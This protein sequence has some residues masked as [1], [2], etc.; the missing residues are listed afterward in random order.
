MK[1]LGFPAFGM[2]SFGGVGSG[3]FEVYLTYDKAVSDFI[4][5]NTGDLAY[6]CSSVIKHALLERFK[7]ARQLL[8]DKCGNGQE[9]MFALQPTIDNIK[10][11]TLDVFRELTSV[12]KLLV[13]RYGRRMVLRVHPG[14]QHDRVMDD[15]RQSRIDRYAEMDGISERADRLARCT[16]VMSYDSTVLWEAFILGLVPVSV[17][18]NC[19]RGDLSFPHEVLDVTSSLE[20]QLENVLRPETA[21]KYRCDLIEE[22]F[23]WEDIVICLIGETSTVGITEDNG[24]ARVSEPVSKTSLRSQHHTSNP[25]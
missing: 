12:A 21:K 16:V 22:G 10:G 13:E 7:V 20:A 4:R 8:S 25:V 11:S 23:D 17:H 2:G 5:V 6:E 15:Y 24:L 14:M 19:Y 1:S 9:V 3:V 18:G